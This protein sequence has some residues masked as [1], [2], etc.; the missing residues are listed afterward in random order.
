V[1]MAVKLDLQVP[2]VYQYDGS[3]TIEDKEYIFEVRWSTDTQE[4]ETI[5]W[6]MGG[7]P[8]EGYIMKAEER[9]VNL[10]SKVI[11]E[12]IKTIII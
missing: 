3:V 11:K 2:V 9:I 5:D 10:V 12:D 8:P 6:V 7:M 4:V 1:S